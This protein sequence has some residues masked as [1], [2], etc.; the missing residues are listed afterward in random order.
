MKTTSGAHVRR[1]T[2]RYPLAAGCNGY[3]LVEILI[4]IAIFSIGFMAVGTMILSTTRNNTTG[5]IVTQATMLAAETLEELKR[6]PITNL[7]IG[8]PVNDPDNPITG[9]GKAGGIYTRSWV[10]DD[11]VGYNTSR[12]ITV[13]VRWDRLG[14]NRAV[15][16]ATITRGNGT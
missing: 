9:S 1:T 10:I 5:N 2:C 4:A 7:A 6:E 16:L 14:Q 3:L 13:T 15:Q 11:P 12:R 8:G